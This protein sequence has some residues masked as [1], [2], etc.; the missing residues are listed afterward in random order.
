MSEL[1]NFLDDLDKK[2]PD[3]DVPQ[4][5]PP[6]NEPPS[7]EPPQGEPS[8]SEP[9]ADEP[10]VSEPP[11]DEPPSQEGFEVPEKFKDKKPEDI[12][13]SYLELEKKLGSQGEELGALRKQVEILTNTLQSLPSEPPAPPQVQEPSTEDFA[14]KLAEE[15][16]PSLYEDPTT[17]TRK[18]IHGVT[19]YIEKKIQ[20]RG[21]AIQT[22]LQQILNTQAQLLYDTFISKYPDLK[23]NEA[24]LEMAS[25]QITSQPNWHAKYVKNNT[26]D[27]NA[28]WKDLAETA[29]KIQG[30]SQ[31]VN[32][33]E[34]LEKIGL[35]QATIEKIKAL[36]SGR[37]PNPSTP[38]AKNVRPT[39]R[40]STQKGVADEIMEMIDL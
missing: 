7:N 37:K 13:K 3:N 5:S 22:G 36:S 24:V 31:P 29:R 38:P 16:A 20:D 21:T 34:Q 25:R 6:Q 32:L 9:P 28:Y 12:I 2:E 11:Q 15:V 26:F 8:P 14:T 4:G 39:N 17:S 35:D 23:D 27:R 30:K 40:I 1:D 33:V 10:P 18:L 19:Q